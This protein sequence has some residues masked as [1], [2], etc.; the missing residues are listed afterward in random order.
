MP[1]N[2]DY[3]TRSPVIHILQKKPSFAIQ[4]Y[5][6]T[7][8]VPFTVE[9]IYY[10]EALSS[11]PFP[12]LRH[13]SKVSS[14]VRIVAAE[15]ILSYMQDNVY[16]IDK[17]LTKDQRILNRLIC[18]T[19]AKKLDIFLLYSHWIG[20]CFRQSD[21]KKFFADA[22]ETFKNSM[23]LECKVHRLS[24]LTSL[25]VPSAKVLSQVLP[26]QLSPAVFYGLKQSWAK[27]QANNML[28][29]SFESIV[30]ETEREYTML[31]GLLD[32]SGTTYFHS[33]QH[34]STGDVVVFEHIAN[35]R[36]ERISIYGNTFKKKY[37]NLWRLYTEINGLYFSHDGRV[38][39]HVTVN[40]ENRFY[41]A[42]VNNAKVQLKVLEESFKPSDK[43]EL[44]RS[45]AKA[46]V[47]ASTG[48]VKGTR[49]SGTPRGAFKQA[50][51]YEY[52]N[53]NSCNPDS[54]KPLKKAVTK[55]KAEQSKAYW[56]KVFIGGI[57]VLF[58][59]Y[60]VQNYSLDVEEEEISLF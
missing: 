49:S 40:Q 56:N 24:Y 60:V 37:P 14:R 30:S 12:Q 44:Q 11:G 55:T 13:G 43:P 29:R 39:S 35:A 53:S 51:H 34:P 20:W 28:H 52:D 5:L 45:P 32:E 58:G 21:E 31:E 47:S 38:R 48:D 26:A 15:D 46:R 27:L 19:V 17:N 2:G 41:V 59:F 9:N 50:H 8:E 16:D 54:A 57:V 33:Q 36:H 4:A 18:T 23:R 22:E 25:I 10:S 7:A 42:N 1:N 3:A 6:L